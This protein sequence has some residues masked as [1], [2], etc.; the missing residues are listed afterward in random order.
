MDR[1]PLKTLLFTA[2]LLAG[3]LKF[4]TGAAVMSVDLGSEWMKVVK[5]D[6]LMQFFRLTCL[7]FTGRRRLTRRAHGN[8]LEQRVQ[9]KVANCN[10]F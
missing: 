3:S 2:V 7:N 10:S 9:E 5:C 8:S 6:F 4:A 1:I